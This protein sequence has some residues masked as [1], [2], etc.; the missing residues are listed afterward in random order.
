MEPRATIDFETRSACDLKKAGS[1]RYSL[2]L[3]TEILCM[4]FRLPY[5]ETGRTG[6]WHPAFPHLG[7][8][9][10][11]PTDL[12][13]L[14]DWLEAGGLVEAHQ[15]WFERGIWLNKFAHLGAPAIRHEQWR[16][17]MAKASTHALERGLDE[18]VKAL[19][20]PLGKDEA[21][22]KV[23]RKVN[24]PRK[25]IQRDYRDW[26]R[27]H[28][29]CPECTGVGKVQEFKKDGS[30]KTKLSRCKACAGKGH[31]Q[32]LENV[33]EMPR[34]WH[35][36]KELFD[37]LFAY[38]R[39]DVLAE[40][41][42]SEALPDLSPNETRVYLMDQA[43]NER[44][45]R[46]DRKAM[47][48][49]LRVAKVEHT[50]L[51][52]ELFALTNG[53]VD[54]V[55]QRDRM[56]EWFKTVGL[57][58]F[59]TTKETVASF[60]DP[61]CK[62]PLTDKARRGLELM[63]LLGKA[64]TA[65]YVAMRKQIC[66]DNRV[67]GG[68][69]Y[70][71]AQT[72]RW[73]GAGVQPHNFPK[74][75]INDM[76]EAWRVIKIQD[77]ERIKALPKGKKKLPYNSVM[78]VLSHALRGAIVPSPGK[79]LYVADYAAIEARVLLWLAQDD[80]ALE[81]FRTGQDIYC[82]MADDIYGYPTNKNDHPKERGLGKIAVLG[83]GYQMGASKFV[84]SCALAGVE[85]SEEFA[86]KVVD[87]YRAK[88]W[89]VKQL[90][91]DMNEAAIRA[92]HS[93]G[94]AQC[95]CVTWIWEKTPCGVPYLYC[96]LPSGRRIAYPEP[97]LKLRQTPWGSTQRVLTFMG[98]N[99]FN[100]QWQ[101]QHT[102]GGSLVENVVQAISRDLMAEAMLRCEASGTYELVLSVHDELVAEALLG[103]GSVHEFEQLMSKLPDWAPGCP[104]AAEGWAGPRYRK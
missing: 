10:A 17:S 54:R 9:E 40:E 34:L 53:L 19:H 78:T 71:G 56:I 101:R 94:R 47:R 43:V 4:A 87:A 15:A 98:L 103:T 60:L 89:R 76:S 81:V 3:T 7:I 38:C 82:Y 24:K 86:Q 26:N 80:D 46:L 51:N 28:A 83:L 52:A 96:E 20:L 37:I 91:T 99:P 31:T 62:V 70:H 85:V 100:H 88:F 61:L 69:L 67:H 21:G 72:G 36:S 92:V 63:Q 64:S 90:W 79:Q 22:S 41:G 57:Q 5:W 49:A 13:E 33:P 84:E 73:S 55:S 2:D 104:V 27:K 18:A 93:K 8:P 12:L 35:E 66:P 75:E 45:Y 16:C 50:V 48:A 1:W 65:K 59:D 97:Q 14:F 74:G 39:Q 25:P 32:Q 23:M 77:P 42:F 44:G 6:L 95:G 58:L 29:P 30:P 102:Y 11:D 68:L